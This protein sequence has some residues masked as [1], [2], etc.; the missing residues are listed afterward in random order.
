MV[1]STVT[2]VDVVTGDD[3][4]WCAYTVIHGM[5]VTITF[6]SNKPVEH[7]HFTNH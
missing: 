2:N 6:S 7:F 1:L 4:C 5:V 3:R